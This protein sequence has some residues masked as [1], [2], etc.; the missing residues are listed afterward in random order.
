LFAL[1]GPG[2]IEHLGR[3]LQEVG[4]ESSYILAVESI[5][6]IARAHP[7]CSDKV[8]TIYRAYM[9]NPYRTLG[10][11]NGLLVGRLL[12]LDVKQT[13]DEIRNL[14]AFSSVDYSCSGDLEEVEA[15]LGNSNR[16]TN[17]TSRTKRQA[18][19]ALK[20]LRLLLLT[21]IDFDKNDICYEIIDCYLMLYGSDNAIVGESK[22]DGY[23]AAIACAPEP[24]C[25]SVWLPE[26]C[27]AGAHSSFSKND[28]DLKLFHHC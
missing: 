13:I 2:A 15:L 22:M 23:F 25:Q 5:C 18:L 11:L 9:A 10:V 16:Q 7:L 17:V 24:I 6:K 26:I 19:L 3:F 21:E 1:I 28:A 20:E 14:F 12:E 4:A 8:I 27:G